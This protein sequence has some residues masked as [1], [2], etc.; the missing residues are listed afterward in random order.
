MKKFRLQFNTKNWP[1]ASISNPIPVYYGANIDKQMGICWLDITT[2]IGE[3]DLTQDASDGL[4]V[5]HRKNPPDS[6]NE[7]IEIHLYTE[8]SDPPTKTIREMLV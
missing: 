6:N 1:S 8:Q 3:F 4:Y 5:Y 2:G 7:I